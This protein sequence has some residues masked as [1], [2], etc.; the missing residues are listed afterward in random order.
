MNRMISLLPV[1]IFFIL[2]SCQSNKKQATADASFGEYVQSFTSGMVSTESVIT[3]HLAQPATKTVRPGAI[4]FRFSPVIK[5]E[6]VLVSDR[7][8]EFRPSEPLQAGTSYSAEFFLDE[9]FETPDG[10]KKMPF[11]FST[12]EQSFSLH[13][14]GLK[15]YENGPYTKTQFTGTLLTADVA[16]FAETEK[17]V[18][19]T[20]EGKEIALQWTHDPDRRKHFFTIDSLSRETERSAMLHFSWNGKPLRVDKK[21]EKKVEVPALNVFEILEADVIQEP[22]QHIQ[23]RFSDPFSLLPEAGKPAPVSSAH[24]LTR[25]WPCRPHLNRTVISSSGLMSR[26]STWP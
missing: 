13:F 5:G 8:V 7:E 24:P 25:V 26:I 9:L 11:Q 21:G 17:I 10:L 20:F 3:V 12:I 23:I 18:R 22:E 1:L 6:T 14:G 19:A 4:L 2:I 15:A 16:P